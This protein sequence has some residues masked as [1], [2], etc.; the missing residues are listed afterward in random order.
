MKL[1][2]LE[3]DVLLRASVDSPT[4]YCLELY[5]E[6]TFEFRNLHTTWEL[7]HRRNRTKVNEVVLAQEMLA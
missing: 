6:N 5:Q 7:N 2:L 1:L 4:R 3:Q